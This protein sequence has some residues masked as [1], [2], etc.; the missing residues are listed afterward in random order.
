MEKYTIAELRDPQTQNTI[1]AVSTFYLPPKTLPK[2]DRESQ[3]DGYFE[4]WP[5]YHAPR[6]IHFLGGLN[7]LC[8]LRGLWCPR[9]CSDSKNR[10]PCASSVSIGP[11]SASTAMKETMI[12]LALDPKFLAEYKRNPTLFVDSI[13]WP[14]AIREGCF[15]GGSRK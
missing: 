4:A 10:V 7:Q 3:R 5:G 13:S 14:H 9:K 12:K 15:T 6:A 2:Y 1:N 8:L 11:E